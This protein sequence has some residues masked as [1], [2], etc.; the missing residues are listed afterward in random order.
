M[1]RSPKQI[2]AQTFGHETFRGSQG[3]VISHVMQGGSAL[4]IMPTGFGK[5]L[6]YQIPALGMDGLCVVVSPLIALMKDQT[7]RLRQL[8][9]DAAAINSSLSREEREHR[10]RDLRDGRLDLVHVT[11]E[12]FRKAR[13]RESIAGRKVCLLAIDE[14]H[15]VSEWGHDF[16]PDYTRL[17]EFRQL[18]GN[19]PVLALTATA[20]PEVQLDIARQLG[21]SREALRLFHDGVERP[22]LSLHVSRMHGEDE[23]LAQLLELI[24]SRRGSAIV[25][26]ALIKTL[27]RFS[28][29]LEQRK[30]EHAAYHG[31]L[32]AHE[33]RWIQE[34]FM[35]GNDSIVLATNAFGLGVDKADIGL[36][37]HAEVPGSLEAYAQEIGRAGRDGLPARCVLLYDQ[38]D[39]LIQM[40]FVEWANP[41]ADFLHRLHELLRDRAREFQGPEGMEALRGELVFKSRF[42]FRLETALRL[43]DRHGVCAGSLEE[44][45]LQVVRDELPE[46][47]DSETVIAAK[48]QR[49][50]KRLHDLVRY[51]DEPLCRR[52]FLH[53]H[54][55]FPDEN[56][57]G[58]CD[59]CLA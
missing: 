34:Q 44:R 35:A 51:A 53:G 42:D 2:L 32:R 15:C 24:A 26:F 46:R 40:D 25:Y 27:E 23:K 50:L 38:Q 54:F 6:C 47:L 17:A 21:F 57:C 18:L 37:V 45:T 13:F 11:P 7:D 52:T 5:S 59:L 55:G 1:I 43:F 58:S 31:K 49:D 29:M 22:N 12:R 56:R 20:T 48:K 19:P 33:R 16:R 8:G 39:L 41:E 9:V 4:L 28:R 14:A 3:D 30:I 10:Y 36:V